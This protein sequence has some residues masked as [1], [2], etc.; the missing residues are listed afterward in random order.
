M[1]SGSWG[2]RYGIP[3]IMR[4]GSGG[5]SRRFAA[6][7]AVIPTIFLCGSSSCSPPDK[8]VITNSASERNPRVGTKSR[9]KNAVSMPRRGLGA[10]ISF[11]CSPVRSWRRHSRRGRR[12]F[13][14]DCIW[15]RPLECPRFVRCSTRFRG[16]RSIT[17][18][19]ARYPRC[20]GQTLAKFSGAMA[21]MRPA[22]CRDYLRRSVARFGT[23][24]PAS[25][26]V[27][28]TRRQSSWDRWRR[29]NS[30]NRSSGNNT[31]GS[32]S[33]VPC[34]TALCARSRCYWRSSK[35][36]RARTARFHR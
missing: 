9:M 7:P 33:R 19:R 20:S 32:S 3:S 11:T 22:C 21:A 30:V 17:L 15:S 18:T 28:Q 36:Y 12:H 29:S 10:T 27:F 34:R 31:P 16:S 6:A 2:I 1:H 13:L 4:C 23:F 5:Q 35:P 8:A 24:W 25:C 26:Q 14:T